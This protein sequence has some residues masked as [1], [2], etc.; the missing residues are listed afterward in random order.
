METVP[1]SEFHCRR[2]S[3]E[4]R[5]DFKGPERGFF[6]KRLTRVD[7]RTTYGETMSEP[8]LKQLPQ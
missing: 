8:Y 3:M 4:D 6:P 5:K 1:L 2:K 7:I